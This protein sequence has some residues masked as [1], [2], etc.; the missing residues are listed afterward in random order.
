MSKNQDLIDYLKT[1]RSVPL[2]FL[3]EPGPNEKELEEILTIAIRV[4]DHGKLSPWRLITYAGDARA[5]IGEKLAKIAIKKRKNIDQEAIEVEKNQF[6]P[7]PIT[8]GVLSKPVEHKWISEKEQLL[9]AGCVA[10]NLVHGA[11]ALGFGAHWVT[12]WFSVDE[13]AKKM[14]GAKTGEDFV[15]FIHIGTAKKTLEDRERP[16]LKNIVSNW[17]G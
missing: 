15:A 13:E 10:L 11:N 12:R 2:P 4:P 3:V 7:A 8:I 9:S 17:Q 14:L 1:R 6:L 16:D 5:E